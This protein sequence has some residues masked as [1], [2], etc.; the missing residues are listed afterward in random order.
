MMDLLPCPFCGS[1]IK[2]IESLAKSFDPP[3]VYHEWHHQADNR[4][5]CP[6][7][8]HIGIV[9][10][11]ATDDKVEQDNAIARWNTRRV[12]APTASDGWILVP[13]ALT[14]ENGA[15][16]ALIGDFS[17]TFDYIDDE[18]DECTAEIPV[19]WDTIKSIHKAMVAHFDD[20][21][22]PSS[23]ASSDEA[24][25]LPTVEQIAYAID[26]WAFEAKKRTKQDGG[27]AS[28]RVTSR[29]DEA[30]AQ[31][32]RVFALLPVIT[33]TQSDARTADAWQDI[34]TAPK[35]GTHIIAW[36]YWSGG[37]TEV[38]WREMHRGGRWESGSGY[39]PGANPIVWMPLPTP[40][41]PRKEGK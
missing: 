27:V 23:T 10:A 26:G 32:S 24:T 8:R 31:A 28:H 12:S 35:D 4:G 14:A 41:V 36:P 5:A 30:L 39:C 16:A 21:P 7:R 17:E 15:K 3:R 38:C 34:S 29:C 22:V 18:G 6:V 9:I 40:P 2:H 13:R 37:S 11:S 1:E 33:P 25:L 19:S 20:A